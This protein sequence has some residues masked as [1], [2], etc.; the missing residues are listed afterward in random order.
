MCTETKCVYFLRDK[1]DTIRMHFPSV[2]ALVD[3]EKLNNGMA[4]VIDDG[5]L[6]EI[7]AADQIYMDSNPLL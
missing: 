6:L 3:V 4:S 2:V 1:P 7:C 5:Q